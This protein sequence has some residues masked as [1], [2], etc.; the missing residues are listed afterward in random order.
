METPTRAQLRAG[1]GLRTPVR[2]TRN[3]HSDF[4]EFEV[5]KRIRVNKYKFQAKSPYVNGKRNDS[6]V[7]PHFKSQIV[8][9]GDVQPVY[10]KVDPQARK[11]PNNQA[12]Y[13]S[14]NNVRLTTNNSFMEGEPLMTKQSKHSES[15]YDFKRTN[16]FVNNQYN[17]SIEEKGRLNTNNTNPEKPVSIKPNNNDYQRA[18]NGVNSNYNSLNRYSNPIMKKPK[19]LEITLK[20][21][22]Q[23]NNNYLDSKPQKTQS[24]KNN[25]R[26]DSKQSINSDQNL[27]ELVCDM[28]Y[29]KDAAQSR[30]MSRNNR[31]PEDS[32]NHPNDFH[33][34]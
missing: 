30:N 33:V 24:E 4:V 27:A 5:D 16:P 26:K 25:L 17:K 13:R 10:K 18:K 20:E 28:C 34:Q 7:A 3:H 23:K 9:G 1:E 11:T 32:F 29:N 15:N 31:D 8:L 21:E 22:N 12:N 14:N 2:L 6:F 19:Q